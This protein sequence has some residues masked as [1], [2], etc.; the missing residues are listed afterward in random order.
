M[1][2]MAWLMISFFAAIWVLVLAW[3]VLCFVANWR[4]FK[5]AG[6]PGWASIVPFYNCYIEYG[7][8]WGNGWI[9]VIPIV[10]GLLSGIP[11]LGVVTGIVTL[12][13]RA[14][15]CYKKAVAFGEGIG[16]AIGLFF[17]PAI[18]A[19][20]LAFGSYRYRGVPQDGFSYQQLKRKFEAFRAKEQTY[21]YEAPRQEQK[22]NVNYEA[23]RQERKP[24][25]N[26]EAPEQGQ[27]PHVNDEAPGQA[28]KPDMDYEAPSL[29][30]KADAAYEAS[31]R[32]STQE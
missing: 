9:F 21:T 5:K 17:L 1:F 8:Y 23:P 31:D 19:M 20:I 6:Q 11:I 24:N 7:I 25:V 30:Q 27:K 13:I 15:T 32:E 16:F 29:E 3:I 28:Q 10:L 22:P 14:M 12:I 26:Y 4:I 2:Q 18:F